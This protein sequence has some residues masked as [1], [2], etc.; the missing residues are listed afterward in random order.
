MENENNIKHDNDTDNNKIW[1]EK[2]RPHNLNDI[3]GHSNIIKCIKNYINL[4]NFPHLLFYGPPG[5]GKTTTIH[6]CSIELYG[7]SKNF[8]VLEL[9]ASDERGIEVVRNRIQQFIASSSFNFI[10]NNNT[11]K[12]KLVILDEID[13]MTNDAQSVLRKVMEMYTPNARF[14]LICNQI[15]NINPALQSRCSKFRFKQL[16]HEHMKNKINNI[17]K[18]ERM[19]I[20]NEAIDL[21]INKS[22]GDMRKIYNTM[23]V[24]YGHPETITTSH[25]NNYFNFIKNGDIL[26]IIHICLNDNYKDAVNNITKLKND[27]NISLKNIVDDTFNILY[28]SI[29]GNCDIKMVNDID[30]NKKSIIITKLNNIDRNMSLNI[31]EFIQLCYFISIFKNE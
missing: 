13:I 15:K 17:I 29:I 20:E 16:S 9:N 2:Y 7:K 28:N 18:E 12:F 24:I 3:L 4:K 27:N 5:T 30:I 11:N 23:Q 10:E 25:I 8:M 6:A 19:N 14:C 31:N 21:I 22:N 26:K 1:S